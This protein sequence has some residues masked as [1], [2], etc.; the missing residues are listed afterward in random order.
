MN[1]KQRRKLQEANTNK[2]VDCTNVNGIVRLI[3]NDT[4]VQIQFIPDDRNGLQIRRVI[5]LEN[6][7]I[8]NA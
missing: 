6:N 5:D 2:R 8:W 7:T 1:I 4:K 3:V